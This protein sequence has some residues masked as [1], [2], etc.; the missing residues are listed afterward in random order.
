MKGR[1]AIAGSGK[2]NQ[3]NHQAWLLLDERNA[4]KFEGAEMLFDDALRLDP[5][6]VDAH[7]GKAVLFA[8]MGKEEAAE[9]E[10]AQAVASAPGSSYFNIVR[11]F[12]RMMYHWDWGEAGRLMTPP[13]SC[14][15]PICFQ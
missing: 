4:T 6:S 14:S 7:A 2:I 5:H 12:N 15:R 11:G 8:L 10:A 13:P 3:I 9:S 1:G